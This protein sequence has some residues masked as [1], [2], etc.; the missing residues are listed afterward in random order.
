MSFK[1][2]SVKGCNQR[3]GKRKAHLETER[4]NLVILWRRWAGRS[5]KGFTSV[6]RYLD[7]Y[8]KDTDDLPKK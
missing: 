6:F 5:P 4:Q 3:I 7:F 8:K 1:E 2:I